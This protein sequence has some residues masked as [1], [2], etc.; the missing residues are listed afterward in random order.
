MSSPHA[1]DEELSGETLVDERGVK[2]VVYGAGNPSLISLSIPGPYTEK[3]SSL[4]GSEV[5]EVKV[6]IEKRHEGTRIRAA[7]TE[8]Y[9]CNATLEIKMEKRHETFCSTKCTMSAGDVRMQVEH[10]ILSKDQEK[11]LLSRR[12]E[13]AQLALNVMQ[14]LLENDHPQRWQISSLILKLSTR[15]NKLP[16]SLVV[17]DVTRLDKESIAGG[18]FAD[19]YR[20]EYKGKP[21]ALKRLRVYR[22]NDDVRAWQDF[23]REAIIWKNL[24]HDHV[25]PLLGVDNCTFQ[26][27][28]CMV[29]P[30]ME[31]GNVR[32]VI[33]KLKEVDE[34]KFAAPKAPI[35]QVHKWLREIAY[36]LAYLHKESIVHG[37]LRGANIL[38]DENWGVR[39]TDF[40]M[41]VYAEGASHSYGSLRGGNPRWMAPELI[42]PVQFFLVSDRPTNAS[43]IFSFACCCV[44]LFSG[45]AP[46]DGC[47]ESQV[48]RRVPEGLRPG[49]PN[50]FVGE[51]L[52]SDDLWKLVTHCWAP[53]LASR[54]NV[55]EVVREISDVC[56]KLPG[57]NEDSGLSSEFP[58][59]TSSE[60]RNKMKQKQLQELEEQTRKPS[61]R[62]AHNLVLP[63]FVVAQVARWRAK[64]PELDRWLITAAPVGRLLHS[65][66]VK[67]FFDKAVFYFFCL[68]IMS[69]FTGGSS[70]VFVARLLLFPFRATFWVG[71]LVLW[72]VFKLCYL[73]LWACG[74]LLHFVAW[75]IPKSLLSA[76]GFELWHVPVYVLIY[77]M[78]AQRIRVS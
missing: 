35:I 70:H 39:L 3:P 56:D 52:M 48:V 13:D 44:E 19:I 55:Q 30:W 72:L 7:A 29:I 73:V 58:K 51:D 57:I 50:A 59:G 33:D 32:H 22:T 61:R 34:K 17:N 75:R 4:E 23:Y 66:L 21:V 43:D 42:D 14:K 65:V 38:I 9:A 28:L 68:I 62:A 36:G 54:P 49:R 31:Y 76:I 45:K 26:Q 8:C 77:A 60:R 37:D 1:V 6:K 53:E 64:Y 15:S 47:G 11:M 69:I 20:G 27:N 63:P 78:P 74:I 10:A 5:I 18:G 2:E 25:L 40:G 71:Y 16:A 24:D 46:Y 67:N 41:A 12:D